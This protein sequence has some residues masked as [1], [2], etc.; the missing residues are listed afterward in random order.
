MT[1][2]AAGAVATTARSDAADVRPTPANSV[3]RAYA[4]FVAMSLY[5]VCVSVVNLSP[6]QTLLGAARLAFVFPF[7]YLARYYVRDDREVQFFLKLFAVIIALGA[8]SLPLQRV[9]GPVSWFA[10]ASSRAGFDR[11]SSIFGNLTAM[12]NVGGLALVALFFVDVKSAARVLLVVCLLSGMLLTLQKAAILNIILAIGIYA[13]LRG[14]STAE[15]LKF[16]LR[17]LTATVALVGLAIA[18]IGPA[19]L[20]GIQVVFRLGS[21]A[22]SIDDVSVKASL[23][24][25]LVELPM[26]LY[27]LYGPMSVLTGVG[28]KGGGGVMG[29]PESP[30]SH[31]NFFDL[32]FLG[33]VLYLLSFLALLWYTGRAALRARAAA[34]AAGNTVAFRNLQIMTGIFVLFVINL[35]VASGT[36]FQPNISSIFW[37]M[38]G[39]LAGP[40][41]RLA[42]AGRP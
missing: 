41:A 1:D 4:A 15:R 11:F 37:L 28:L 16:G 26:V 2:G 35:P 32:L 10:E 22:A 24:E 30:M 21:S 6:A 39:V 20:A 19:A 8:L 25:R 7:A 17:V 9:T 33:G 23:L 40:Y 38:V 5:V 36:I 34:R 42:D 18:V 3:L 12:G 31:N 14:R 27:N 13:I 29:M